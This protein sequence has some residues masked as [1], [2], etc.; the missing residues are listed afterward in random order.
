MVREQ[1]VHAVAFE[2]TRFRKWPISSD[3]DHLPT[4]GSTQ[5]CFG[6]VSRP[7]V[8]RTRRLYVQSTVFSLG[9]G[10][11][12]RFRGIAPTSECSQSRRLSVRIIIYHDA[13]QNRTCTSP[14]S[15]DVDQLHMGILTLTP[16]E[17]VLSALHGR[18]EAKPCH[19]AALYEGVTKCAVPLEVLCLVVRSETCVIIP[20]RQRNSAER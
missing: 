20:L 9:L 2:L 11:K 13:E 8:K 12:L 5:D 14:E 15:G 4:S 16:F 19:D 10:I 7:D 18:Q 1:E 3:H 17:P 6:Q